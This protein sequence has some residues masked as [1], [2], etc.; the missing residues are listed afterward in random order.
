M[1]K[2]S[3]WAIHTFLGELF[4]T[5]Q[6][7]EMFDQNISIFLKNS[8]H[9][10]FIIVMILY[11]IQDLLSFKGFSNLKGLCHQFRIILK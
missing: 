9:N 5:I 4:S 7:N 1:L 6:L 2:Y 11:I 8:Y 3:I 10:I